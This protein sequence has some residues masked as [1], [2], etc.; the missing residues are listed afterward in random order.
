[1]WCDA[2]VAFYQ[3]IFPSVCIIE[4]AVFPPDPT[5]ITGISP[6]DNDRCRDI[7]TYVRPAGDTLTLSV[8]VTADPCPEV[9]W[10][11]DGRTL[12]E[13]EASAG[14]NMTFYTTNSCSDFPDPATGSYT[15]TID[16]NNITDCTAGRYTITLSNRAGDVTSDPVFVTPEGMLIPWCSRTG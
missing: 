6:P 8:D 16:I 1:M 13:V 12:A 14:C 11:V 10:R 4:Y 3:C 9:E 2:V 5:V 15:F 7:P